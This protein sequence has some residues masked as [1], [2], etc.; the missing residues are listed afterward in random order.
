MGDEID[1]VLWL[2]VDE[3]E[4]ND[5]FRCLAHVIWYACC[6]PRQRVFVHESLDMLQS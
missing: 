4:M 2:V 3:R 1:E 5:K 6:S